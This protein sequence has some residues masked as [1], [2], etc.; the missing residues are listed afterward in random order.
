LFV[1]ACHH[2]SLVLDVVALSVTFVALDPLGWNDLMGG[3]LFDR[4][5]MPGVVEDE[6]VVLI[7]HSEL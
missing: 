4:S 7:I 2:P 5:R 1:P 3:D 6:S